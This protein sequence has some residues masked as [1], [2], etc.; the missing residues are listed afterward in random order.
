MSALLILFLFLSCSTPKQIAKA[1]KPA[2]MSAP[3]FRVAFGSCNNQDQDQSFW[4]LVLKQNPQVWLWLGDNIYADT[5]VPRVLKAKYQKLLDNP[6]YKA[7]AKQVRITGTWDDHDFGENDAGASF[8][9]RRVSKDLFWDFMQVPKASILRSQ[10]GVY[11]AEV[12]KIG[13]HQVKLLILDSRYNRDPLKKNEEGEYLPTEGDMLGEK[14]WQWFEKELGEAS[15]YD[16]VVVA[17]GT[18]VLSSKHPFEK[19][20]NFPKSR[21]RLLKLLDESPVKTKI[22]LSG[23]RHFGEINQL[24]LPS[25]ALLT[26]VVASGLTHS[27]E[28]ANEPNE[29][30]VGPLWPQTHFALMDFFETP[31]LLRVRLSIQDIKTQNI[32]NSIE[33]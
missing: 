5:R 23:Y 32:V 27:Y 4:E 28:A 12:W 1:V 33:L 6:H 11:R 9:M 18:Q 19:W 30:R 13:S 24:K 16:V 3:V 31:D 20:A 22:L 17:N 15:S 10:E 2:E 8:P 25:G 29:M 26:E 21:E 7:L 14:Q